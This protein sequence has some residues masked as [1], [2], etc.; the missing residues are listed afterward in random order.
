MALNSLSLVIGLYQGQHTRAACLPVRATTS[1]QH[2]HIGITYSLYC[3]T[4][5]MGG[6]GR[7]RLCAN[8][9]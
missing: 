6:V 1:Y 3:K 8:C 4:C 7:A 5:Q 9:I 2:Q